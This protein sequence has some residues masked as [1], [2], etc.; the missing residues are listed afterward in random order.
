MRRLS[1]QS[2][3]YCGREDTSGDDCPDG[4]V[5]GGLSDPGESLVAEGARGHI[6]SIWADPK[7]TLSVRQSFRKELQPGLGR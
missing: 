4:E 3:G 7:D 2:L 5:A 6:P 1:G